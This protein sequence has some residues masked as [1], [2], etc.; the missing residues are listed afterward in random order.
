MTYRG[1][2]DLTAPEAQEIFQDALERELVR[3]LEP[4]LAYESDVIDKVRYNQLMAG[5]Y[6]W[7]QLPDDELERRQADTD[8]SIL[9]SPGFAPHTSPFPSLYAEA[10]DLRDQVKRECPAALE[11]VGVPPNPGTIATALMQRL[12]GREAAHERAQLASHPRIRTCESILGTLLDQALIDAIRNGLPSAMQQDAA[13]R[14]QHDQQIYLEEDTRHFADVIEEVCA[15]IQS[16]N[17]WNA[18]LDQRQRIMNAFAWIT[19]NKPL[20]DY[21]PS[22]IAAFKAA[23]VRLPTTFRWKKYWD[24][25]FKEVIAQFPLK[26]LKDRR[27][28]RTINR[29]LSTMARVSSQLALTSWKPAN[30]SE[31]L[32]M[33]FAQH[34]NSINPDDGDDPDRLPWTV[35]HLKVFFASSV[36]TGGGGRTKRLKPASLPTVYHDASYWAPLIAVYAYMSRE[37]VCG[38]EL[39]DIMLDGPVPYLMVRRNMTKSLDGVEPAGLKNHN[40][41]RVV[42]LHPELM[43]LG[44]KDYVEAVAA[45]GHGRLFPE[46]YR[47]PLKVRGGTR[48]YASS[49]RYQV[50]A[51]DAVL[52]LPAN[53]KDK[54]PDFHSFRTF[55]GSHFEQADTKQLTVDRLLGHAPTG[56]GPRKYS[57]AKFTVEEQVYLQNYMDVL[58]R[59]APNVTGHLAKTPVR[60][61]KLE[62]RSA[63]G[64]APGRRGSLSKAQKKARTDKLV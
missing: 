48:F 53:S 20:C 12:R 13:P 40:R 25:P 6:R 29:D 1:R 17:D 8:F 31:T 62:H 46:L 38:L 44:F 63:T 26:P 36:Y 21:R 59:V 37:E 61:L 64:S 57:K 24:R 7:A 15:A 52:P 18:A 39:A 3:A 43:R 35:E 33:N 54:T 47:E 22:H 9:G 16:T 19:G 32:I 49:F 45:E 60:L 30:G 42:P 56:T 4:H 55:G 50:D 2:S 51:V 11:R 23:L 27:H 34:A 58:V 14:Q 41:K 5:L 10:R 28:D